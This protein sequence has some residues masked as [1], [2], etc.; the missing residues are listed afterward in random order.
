MID[1]LAKQL[2][3]KS[4]G[5]I[6]HHWIGLTGPPGSGKSTIA[7]QLKA[8]LAER[9]IVIPMD[10]YH[11]YRHELDAMPDPKLAHSRRGAPFTFNVQRFVEDLKQARI[12]GQGTFPEFSHGLGDPVEGAIQL[13]VEPARIVL[14]EGNYLLLEETPWRQLKD[15]VFHETWFV[16]VPIDVCRER[17]YERHISVGQTPKAAQK[18]VDHNDG[19]NAEFVIQSCRHL[20]DR[21]IV[22]QFLPDQ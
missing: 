20:A 9:I 15:L 17:V 2:I 7:A 1:L 14:V 10:G 19:P 13:K 5:L 3:S 11:F 22:N 18:R 8:K 21:L 12:S 4:D 6:E 16:D